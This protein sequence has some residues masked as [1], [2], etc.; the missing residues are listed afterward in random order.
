[1][2]Q[3][4]YLVD[5]IMYIKVKQCYTSK[6]LQFQAQNTFKNLFQNNIFQLHEQKQTYTHKTQLTLSI[7]WLGTDFVPGEGLSARLYGITNSSLACYKSHTLYI[8]II[9]TCESKTQKQDENDH[10][11]VCSK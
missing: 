3:R 1:M 11:N 8:F 6:C 4:Y 9:H 7:N 10:C 2:Q 5:N